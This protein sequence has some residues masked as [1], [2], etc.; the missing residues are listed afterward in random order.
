MSYN[1][2]NITFPLF[3]TCYP[4]NLARNLA[5]FFD[6]IMIYFL[7]ACLLIG[8]GTRVLKHSGNTIAV[9]HSWQE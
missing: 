5:R 1:I 7:D 4:Q 2:K 8:K 3:N 6:K 9:E